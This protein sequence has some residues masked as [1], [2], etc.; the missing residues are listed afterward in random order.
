VDFF[1]NDSFDRDGTP[2]AAKKFRTHVL[3][4]ICFRQQNNIKVKHMTNSEIEPTICFEKDSGSLH[5][6]KAK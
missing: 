6:Q 2:V 1:P 4:Q 3:S 5:S